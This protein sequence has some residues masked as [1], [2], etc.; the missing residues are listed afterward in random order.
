MR[1]SETF[2]IR[3]FPS[4]IVSCD[5]HLSIPWLRMRHLR[6]AS[7]S[8]TGDLRRLPSRLLRLKA[9]KDNK[10]MYYHC[11]THCVLCEVRIE[12]CGSASKLAERA[13]LD[14]KAQL[15]LAQPRED[16]EPYR[17]FGIS[18]VSAQAHSTSEIACLLARCM[19]RNLLTC[20][21]LRIASTK[22]P[23]AVSSRV[24]MLAQPSRSFQPKLC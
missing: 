16:L 19:C 13:A 12:K 6:I 17:Y 4:F 7:S 9:L 23:V 5:L 8:T 18:S 21:R 20:L 22:R 15:C 2:D 11:R 1:M 3:F 10:D 14:L 24:K